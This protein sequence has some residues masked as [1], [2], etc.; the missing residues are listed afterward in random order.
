MV[1][2]WLCM[3]GRDVCVCVPVRGSLVFK[4]KR[5]GKGA[6][7][8]IR[9]AKFPVADATDSR[10]HQR[11][12]HTAWVKRIV[13]EPTWMQHIPPDV[14][15]IFFYSFSFLHFVF[16]LPLL[17]NPIWFLIKNGYLALDLSYTHEYVSLIISPNRVRRTMLPLLPQLI[18]CCCRSI[19]LLLFRFSVVFFFFFGST[20]VTRLIMF[21]SNPF[22][23]PVYWLGCLIPR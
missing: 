19:C 17:F 15:L 2:L 22:V 9:Y 3:Y 7:N 5:K 18:L 12:I 14:A 11:T 10:W 6:P 23:L 13:K 21:L 16:A 1:S 4:I 20:E 8:L